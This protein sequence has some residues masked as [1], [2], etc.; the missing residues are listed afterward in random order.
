MA[1]AAKHLSIYLNDHLTGSTF[2]LEVV[3]H[4]ATENEGAELGDFLAE[5]KSEIEADRSTLEQIMSSLDASV[6][7]VKR[8]V[9]WIA[10]KVARM[11][12]N[13]QLIGYSRLSRLEE[14]E[15]LSIGIEGKRLL[16]VALAD[17]HAEAV[18][19]ELLAELIARAERQRADVERHRIAAAQQTLR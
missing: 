15:L 11:K 18:G 6:D 19:A 17:T 9:A 7:V 13:G 16:W 10:E 4:A 2:A 8:P 12:L 5:L 1:D 14:L 3:G